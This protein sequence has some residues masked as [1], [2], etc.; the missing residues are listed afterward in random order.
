MVSLH[1]MLD[2]SVWFEGEKFDGY[3]FHN[4]AQRSENAAIH[5]YVTTSPDHLGFGH[6]RNACPGRFFASQTLKIILCHMLNYDFTIMVP[7]EGLT[8]SRG[9]H[10]VARSE[11]KIKIQPRHKEV[12]L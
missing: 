12:V 11:I 2:S 1:H 5:K 10:L 9:H 4:L 3:R 7:E 6:G 8:V